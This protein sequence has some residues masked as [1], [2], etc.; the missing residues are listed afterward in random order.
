M[1]KLLLNTNLTDPIP[2]FNGT[3]F[4]I[5]NID[6]GLANPKDGEKLNRST[7]TQEFGNYQEPRVPRRNA[8]LFVEAMFASAC[9]EMHRDNATEADVYP[10]LS[11]FFQSGAAAT[12]PMLYE[13]GG[14]Y[15]YL[16]YGDVAYSVALM[17]TW[18]AKWNKSKVPSC[19][20]TLYNYGE[21]EDAQE[22]GSFEFLTTDS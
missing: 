4:I 15:D 2:V 3:G 17:R 20:G 13:L 9:I 7:W 12:S 21:T 14:D 11:Y 8:V 16:T 5:P 19:N 10:A 6:N 1:V 22:L 18:V